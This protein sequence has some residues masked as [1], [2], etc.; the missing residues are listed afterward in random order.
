MADKNP[1]ARLVSVRLGFDDISGNL[2]AED[3]GSLLNAV[4]FHGIRAANPAGPHFD[5]NLPRPD[6]RYG[7]FLQA[8]IVIVVVFRDYHLG[9]KKFKVENSRFKVD[10]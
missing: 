10:S 9:S 3:A 2:M 5:Q 1:L 8:D 6:L 7:K 4:P